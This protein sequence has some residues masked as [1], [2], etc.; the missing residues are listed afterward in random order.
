MQSDSFLSANGIALA[1]WKDS[2]ILESD[3]NK[4]K[5]SGMTSRE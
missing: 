3:L 5:I 1:F 4:I 2:P